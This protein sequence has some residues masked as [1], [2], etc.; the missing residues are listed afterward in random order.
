MRLWHWHGL[1][2]TRR[3]CSTAFYLHTSGKWMDKWSYW[4]IQLR[5][6]DPLKKCMSQFPD[7]KIAS[8]GC[9]MELINEKTTKFTT[10]GDHNLVNSIRSIACNNKYPCKVYHIKLWI[11]RLCYV[12]ETVHCTVTSILLHVQ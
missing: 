7:T 5:K 1:Q 11:T 12:Q 8:Q 6:L 2:K 4:L 9:D 10:F 3:Y